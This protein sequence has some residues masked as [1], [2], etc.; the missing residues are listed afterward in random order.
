MDPKEDIF[1][2]KDLDGESTVPEMSHEEQSF[3]NGVMVRADSIFGMNALPIEDELI[4]PEDLPMSRTASMM[5]TGSSRG[6]LV[7]KPALEKMD[8]LIS[9]L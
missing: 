8:S 5:S 2:V 3:V 9:E 1:T 7:S 6:L 4:Y